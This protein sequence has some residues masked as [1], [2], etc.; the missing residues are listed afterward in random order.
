MP[1]FIEEEKRLNDIRKALIYLSLWQSLGAV[2]L[3]PDNGVVVST[4]FDTEPDNSNAG[5]LGYIKDWV[6]RPTKS[7]FKIANVFN[8]D[9]NTRM[10][11]LHKL[12]Q[13]VGVE[14]SARTNILFGYQGSSWRL[15]T[16][17]YLLRR[18]RQLDD[19]ES[20]VPSDSEIA[21][22]VLV[23]GTVSPYIP[24]EIPRASKKH[25]PI[26]RFSFPN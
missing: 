17:T 22:F 24:K 3:A 9:G 14:P 2:Y 15:H 4:G 1:A 23:A 26:S 16:D 13:V 21:T 25:K 6:V 8:R 18:R 7:L 10:I 11:P 12:Y 19:P 5:L 20:A